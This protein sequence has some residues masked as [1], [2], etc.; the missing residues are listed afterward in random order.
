MAEAAQF[1]TRISGRWKSLMTPYVTLDRQVR[2]WGPVRDPHIVVV[3][4]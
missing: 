2:M 4:V 3:A 1:R